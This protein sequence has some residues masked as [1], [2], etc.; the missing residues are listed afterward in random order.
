MG[1]MYA[2]YMTAKPRNGLMP[3][4]KII[5]MVF[6]VILLVL[7]YVI[8]AQIPVSLDKLHIWAIALG[9]MIS[10]ILLKK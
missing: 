8:K 2:E 6:G 3:I 9:M 5:M 1:D 4:L 10:I 7:K